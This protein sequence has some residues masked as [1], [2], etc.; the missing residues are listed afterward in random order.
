M[1]RLLEA[2]GIAM[3]FGGVKAVDGVS[4][5]VDR[6][7]VLGLIGPNGSGKTT[8]VNVL[9]GYLK[10]TLGRVRLEDVDVTGMK[11][12]KLA[13][14]GVGRSYQLPRLF[15]SLTVRENVE[16]AIR[17]RTHQPSFFRALVPTTHRDPA[18]TREALDLL[19]RIGLARLSEREGGGLSLGEARRAEIARTLALATRLLVLDEPAAGLRGEEA[20]AIG[21]LVRELARDHDLGVLL[22]EHNVPFVREFCA[23][24]TVLNFGKLIAEGPPDEIVRRHEVIEAYLG[25]EEDEVFA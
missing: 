16:V 24:L 12:H 13:A 10:P 6:G 18:V 23:R 5:H 20:D 3:Y 25:D 8:L 19:E 21:I 2:D 7:E 22:I 11:P 9:T 15:K 1:T 4:L 14:S 17:A